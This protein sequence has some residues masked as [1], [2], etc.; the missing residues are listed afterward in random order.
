MK[1]VMR[2][3]ESRFIG[4]IKKVHEEMLLSWIVATVQAFGGS[5]INWSGQGSATLC[6]YKIKSAD[7]QNVLNDQVIWSMD[8]F[9]PY[10]TGIFQDDNARIH[11]A[12][13][14]RVWLRE[15]EESFSN[16]NWL[17][18]SPDLASLKLFEMCWRSV[19]V[20]WHSCHQYKI[21]AK[22]FI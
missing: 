14:V 22:K 17:P 4:V 3:E 15:H 5:I 10:G 6:E 11:W 1:K 20:F 21:L 13:I 18:Q 9:F 19:R 8:F 7:C 16:M 2:A 12:Q